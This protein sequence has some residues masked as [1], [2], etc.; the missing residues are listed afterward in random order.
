[1][2]RK[3]VPFDIYLPATET[4][5]AMK[6]TTLE[7]EVITDA[8][9]Q[10]LVTPESEALIDKTQARYMGLLVGADIKALREKLGLSQ[11]D[12]SDLIG[13]GKKSLSRWEN[14]HEYPSQLVNNLLR[15]L[16]EGHVTPDTLRQMREPV[17]STCK[18]IHFIQHRQQP[19]QNY[20]LAGGWKISNPESQDLLKACYP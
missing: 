9:G 8:S 10:E 18:I 2:N 5:A 14:G 1:M 17:E 7:I 3:K 15:L 19:P 13:C 16:Q 11:D 4:R 12:L 20:D 6:V